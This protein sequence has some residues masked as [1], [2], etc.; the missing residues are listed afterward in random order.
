MLVGQINTMGQNGIVEWRRTGSGY[1]S[2]SQF[3]R[4][5]MPFDV[6][7]PLLLRS[8]LSATR[9]LWLPFLIS[10][11]VGKNPSFSSVLKDGEGTNLCRG[12]NG[13]VGG[14]GRASYP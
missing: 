12:V 6:P 2:W 10:R 8:T 9:V 13:Y 14:I 5:Y 4:R 3:N 11:P 7:C 1:A